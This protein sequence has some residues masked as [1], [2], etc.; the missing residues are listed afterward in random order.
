M[1]AGIQNVFTVHLF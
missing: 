1:L